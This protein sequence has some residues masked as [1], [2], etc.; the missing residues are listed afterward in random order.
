MN[1]KKN[2]IYDI[3]A[4]AGVSIATVSRVLRGENTVTEKTK[5]RVQDVILRLNYQPSAIARGLTQRHSK[6]LGIALPRLDN[7]HYSLFYKGAYDEALK[8]GYTLLVFSWEKMKDANWDPAGMLVERR[9]DGV[10]IYTDYASGEDASNEL[11]AL[12]AIRQYMPVVLIGHNLPTKEYPSVTID[13]KECVS[14]MVEHLASLGHERIALLG[15]LR[16]M[17]TEGTRDAGYFE[18]LK[19]AKLPFVSDYRVYGD[20][21]P[22]GGQTALNELLERLIPSQWPTAV[23][24]ANDLTA[25]GAICAA[26]AHGLRVPED[27][28]IVGCDN[29]FFGA[30]MHPSLTSIDT[31]QTYIGCRAVQMLLDESLQTEEHVPCQLILRESSGGR[32]GATR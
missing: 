18:A 17:Q 20:C 24:A 22:E 30:Y 19:R 11:N 14:L 7:P 21:T 15:G 10:A 4:E 8:A 9:L 1:G 26:E 3:A 27:M 12:R 5:K 32:R 25:M 2:T 13:L 16:D 28:A 31:H 29:L 23:I 6:T